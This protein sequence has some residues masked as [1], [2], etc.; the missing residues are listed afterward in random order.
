VLAFLL[1]RLLF[2]AG[3]VILTAFS[4]YGLVR[5]LRP[6]LYAAKYTPTPGVFSDVDRALLHLDFGG[7]C[8]FTGCPPIKRLWLDGISADLLLLAGGIVFALAFGVLGGLWCASRRGS[9]SARGLEWAAAVLYCTPV[10]VV[11]FGV[12]MLFAPVYGVVALPLFF[13]PHS[14]AP[15][16]DN[17]WDFV[18]SMILPWLIVG[19][20][21]GA[22]ILRLTQ[23]L[24]TDTLGEDFVRTA[25]AKGLPHA[26]VVRR[27]AGP[28]TFVSVAS[29]LGAWAPWMI[30]NMV[31]VEYVFSIP[32]FFRHLKR[33]L[34]QAPGWGVATP[35][36]SPTID[37]PTLQALALW[38]AVLI[39]A[40]GLFA[41]L[42]IMGLDPRI[43]ASGDTI[44]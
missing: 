3:T 35:A 1:R 20:P 22:A 17:L 36:G 4:A 10:Y 41:D 29:L 26:T 38:A 40:L 33:A 18:R 37:I 2:A 27:H 24:A 31:L 9:R 7:A 16:G 28:P 25:A 30:T 23:A 6:E 14:Y 32:G 11:G 8:M 44:G 42:A 12:L 39:V 5:L 34:G 19:A 21:L 15:P 43:R 13:D